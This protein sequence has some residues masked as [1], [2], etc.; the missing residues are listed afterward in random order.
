ME[1]ILDKVRKL[2]RLAR[3]KGASE[4]EAATALAMAQKLMLEH[5]IKDV[6][7]EREIH[8]I[9]GTWFKTGRSIQKWEEFTASAI[10]KLFNCRAV[11][12]RKSGMIRFA[13][14]PE[15]VEV[16]E[17]TYFWVIEQIEKIYKEGLSEYRGMESMSQQTRAEFRTSFKHGCAARVAHRVNEMIANARRTIPDHMAL[18]V[19]DQSQ[20]AADELLRS[21]NVAPGKTSEPRKGPGLKAGFIAGERVQLQSTVKK[22]K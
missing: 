6:E 7:E 1:K 9:F 10:A 18:V 5:N 21:R 22:N 17:I 12:I 13:G 2:L 16:C 20:A 8:A 15:N 11:V 19:I 4:A 14:K 3:D